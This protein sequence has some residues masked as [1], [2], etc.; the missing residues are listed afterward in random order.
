MPPSYT[1]QSARFA[2]TYRLAMSSTYRRSPPRTTAYQAATAPRSHKPPPS[3]E[4]ASRFR[5]NYKK[6]V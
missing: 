5:A 4:S 3:K 1:L 6:N 2:T